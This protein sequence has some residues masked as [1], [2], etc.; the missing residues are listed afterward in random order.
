MFIMTIVKPIKHSVENNKFSTTKYYVWTRVNHGRWTCTYF[1]LAH[2]DEV[3]V[4]TIEKS[5]FI[6]VTVEHH[7]LFLVM[8][9]ITSA[10]I[11]DKRG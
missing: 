7:G 1:L 8:N 10:W 5:Y 3:D 11:F 2:V 4:H 6:I 9:G